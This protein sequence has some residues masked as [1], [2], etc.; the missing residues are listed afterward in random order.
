MQRY[1]KYPTYATSITTPHGLRSSLWRIVPS[2]RITP[3]ATATAESIRNLLSNGT[4]QINAVVP[5]TKR[6]LK[7]LLP[8][9]FPMAIPALP[10]RANLARSLLP[11]LT[12]HFFL[13]EVEPPTLYPFL[14]VCF[15]RVNLSRSVLTHSG[16][17]FPPGGWS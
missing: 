13:S 4:L 15:L 16:P 1:A 17:P 11:G 8:T 3:A 9:I 5:I 14:T 6:M 12:G 2:H 7:I 10:L